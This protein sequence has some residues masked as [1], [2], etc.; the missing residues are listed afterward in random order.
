M[1]LIR[2]RFSS[3]ASA[4]LRLRPQSS[5][6]SL[7]TTNSARAASVSSSSEHGTDDPHGQHGHESHYDP[8]TGWLWGLPP[9]VKYEKEGWEGWMY[10]GFLGSLFVGGV[11]YAFKPDTS[12]VH[13]PFFPFS[14]E[15]SSA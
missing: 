12:Y 14:L 4:S 7:S 3:T 6:R 13:L 2:A 5:V 1:S 9:G 15:M 11:A 10:Y 8:P